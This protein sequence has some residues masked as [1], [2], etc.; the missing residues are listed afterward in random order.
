M[1]QQWCQGNMTFGIYCHL[2]GVKLKEDMEPMEWSLEHRRAM[3]TV[4]RHN[5][6]V[7]LLW[8]SMPHSFF[9]LCSAFCL[10]LPFL[11][12]HCSCLCHAVCPRSF[13]CLIL[14]ESHMREAGAVHDGSTG[15]THLS[16]LADICSRSVEE[17]DTIRLLRA[18]H[19]PCSYVLC[20]L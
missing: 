14:K 3:D 1:A 12:S 6:D 10:V 5:S 4:W 13:P 7:S 9:V 15:H 11:L 17:G 20:A 8:S 18:I 19:H 2:Q 16:G